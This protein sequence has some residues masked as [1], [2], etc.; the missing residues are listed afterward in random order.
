MSKIEEIRSA[1]FG[2]EREVETKFIVPLLELLNYPRSELAEERTIA[3]VPEVFVGAKKKQHRRPDFIVYD[4]GK[5]DTFHAL[6][7]V[8]AKDPNKVPDPENDPESVAQAW[9]YAT[10]LLTPYYVLSNGKTTL[11]YKRLTHNKTPGKDPI[12]NRV[13]QK[14]L[15]DTILSDLRDTL[16]RVSLQSKK[17]HLKAKWSSIDALQAKATA[18]DFVETVSEFIPLLKG[19]IESKYHLTIKQK[20]ELARKFAELNSPNVQ[21]L[22]DNPTD[23][24]VLRA[25]Y[26]F[27]FKLLF[28]KIYED[29]PGF[30]GY[31]F[32]FKQTTLK[33]L[34]ERRNKSLA[35]FVAGLV[36]EAFDGAKE[37]YS[38]LFEPNELF[39]NLWPS[40]EIMAKL[41]REISRYNFRNVDNDMLGDVYHRALMAHVTQREKGAFFTPRYIVKEILDSIPIE[42]RFPAG[43]GFCAADIYCGSGTFL[44]ELYD[45]LKPILEKHRRYD[46]P[47]TVHEKIIKRL[48]GCDI[49]PF[50]TQLTIINLILK[51]AMQRNGWRITCGD[52]FRYKQLLDLGD[53]GVSEFFKKQMVHYRE[54]FKRSF[55][56]IVGNPPYGAKVSDAQKAIFKHDFAEV[57]QGGYDT[58]RFAM[59]QAIEMLKPGGYMGF[60]VPN[61]WLTI[62]SAEKLRRY[63][64]R[65]CRIVRLVNLQQ[66]VFNLKGAAANVDTMLVILQKNQSATPYESDDNMAD[67]CIMPNKIPEGKTPE[68]MLDKGEFVLR[69]SV[70]QGDWR[71]NFDAEFSI[72]KPTYIKLVFSKIESN[73]FPLSEIAKVIA[74]MFPYGEGSGN[75]P[76]TR[77]ITEN[78][79]Y[80]SRGKIDNTYYPYLKGSSISR[81]NLKWNGVY[82]S[83]GEWLAQPGK[84][85]D[86]G[87]IHILLQAIRNLSLK[88]RIIAHLVDGVYINHKNLHIIRE[89]SNDYNPKFVLGILNSKLMNE[90][91]RLTFYG[92][93]YLKLNHIRKLPIRPASAEVQAA[94]AEKVDDM[95]ALNA[96]LVHRKHEIASPST[97]NDKQIEER[98]DEATSRPYKD[99]TTEKIKDKI[100][101]TDAEIDVMV[102]KLYELT[103]D[104]VLIIDP[105]F[106][107]KR[108]EYDS[109][110]T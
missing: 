40:D 72:F 105:D 11:V 61:T 33:E 13:E 80:H 8:E 78:K 101:Q 27:L 18:T 28:A 25:A 2:S 56:L 60:I 99:W 26:N 110:R 21:K 82:I 19:D 89:F 100:A 9:A 95:L 90:Y 38:R 16:N 29:K 79:A 31:S 74:G 66:N 45:R 32:H 106:K 15:D 4:E 22:S 77:E 39:D 84:L 103:Y 109:F 23:D 37:F 93:T 52:S 67:I 73:S 3:N 62:K 58:Y 42:E 5:E 30:S 48:Y 17:K 36:R 96:E 81:Y 43:K 55:D 97:R 87:G 85:E 44:I 102:Y 12:V 53:E 65:H 50:S 10:A 6:F 1:Q 94:F 49:D 83:W 63:I 54:V 7:I 59:Y 20:P 34:E 86:F 24:I 14:S 107:M 68:E 35:S 88:R 98:S 104:E 51:D 71:E 57:R 41:V 70:R 69:H 47:E 75:P 76:Q 108:E 64:L 92:T 46:D 91:Y